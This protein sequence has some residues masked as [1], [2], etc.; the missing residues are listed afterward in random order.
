MAKARPLHIDWLVD[1]GAILQTSCGKSVAVWEL[2]H[3]DDDQVLS[4][5][6]AHFR[7]HYCLDTLVDQLR[8]RLSRKDYL[9]NIKFPSKSSKL[10]PPTRAG[11]FAEILISD[12]LEWRLGFWVPRVRWGNKPT[13]DESPKGSDVIGFQFAKPGKVSPK[14]MLAVFETK[15]GLSSPIG[16]RLQDAV[17]DSAK[18]FLRIDESLNF[19]KQKLLEQ[20]HT[21]QASDVERFQNSVDTP[22]QETYGAAALFSTDSF[23][24][25]TIKA[26]N[27]LKVPSSKKATTVAPHP[28]HNGMQMI[29]IKGDQMMELVHELYR[30]AAHEA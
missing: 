1:T 14:D 27:G 11:D 13:R 25:D 5:W 15:A 28:Y 19:L 23:D 2:K 21:A 20:G 6:A 4:A 26:T 10:G 22:Y 3:E 16:N 12:Y 24:V 18:D 29:V 17:N 9:E 30:R 7:N 8:G